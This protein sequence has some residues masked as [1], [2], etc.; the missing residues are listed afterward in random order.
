MECSIKC[1][2]MYL[3]LQLLWNLS[4]IFF[5]FLESQTLP[6]RWQYITICSGHLR[7]VPNGFLKIQWEYSFINK[8]S[9]SFTILP[10]A[11]LCNWCE[12]LCV[13]SPVSDSNFVSYWTLDCVALRPGEQKLDF[14]NL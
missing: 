2:E 8:L 6:P 10:P 5:H 12:S 11:R 7:K 14:L 3:L 1:Y 13:F 9:Y 4:L